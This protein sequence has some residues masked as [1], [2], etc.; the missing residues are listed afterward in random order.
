MSIK[1]K[2]M[3]S[4]ACLIACA[5][6]A[7]QTSVDRS[8][9]AVSKDCSGI[10]WSERA[11]AAYPGI[12]AACQGV[13]TRGGKTYVKFEGTVKKNV[14]RGEQLV[15]NFKDAGDMTLTPPAETRLYVNGKSTS[16]ADLKRGDELKFYMPRTA[17]GE[18]RR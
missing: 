11:L 10:Q 3:L 6:A 16:V 9:T 8:F 13:E 14:N 2:T 1:T 15:V 17:R 4:A 5:S 18:T 7:A 12:G